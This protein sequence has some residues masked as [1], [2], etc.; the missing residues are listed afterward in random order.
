MYMLKTYTMKQFDIIRNEAFKKMKEG[1][2]VKE[3]AEGIRR[4]IYLASVLMLTGISADKIKNYMYN[5][6][7][8]FDEMVGDNLLKL[9]GL[10]KYL[11]WVQRRYRNLGWTTI[12]ALVP[13]V[14]V[15]NPVFEAF[16]RDLYKAEKSIRKNEKLEIPEDLESVKN[17]PIFGRLYYNYF[18]N[19]EKFHAKR[20]EKEK[21]KKPKK[22]KNRP[23]I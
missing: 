6:E 18:G 20:K 15:F 16:M 4:L 12:K 14:G 11:L 2:T 19:G 9:F 8:E 21:K 1:K 22:K 13:P 7:Q 17:I 23:M 3:K 5:R 10:Q